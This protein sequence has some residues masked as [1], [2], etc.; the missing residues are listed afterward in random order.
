MIQKYLIED[1][2]ERFNDSIK[3][4]EDSDKSPYYYEKLKKDCIYII[5]KHFERS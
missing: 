2:E 3:R 4:C 5:N 1:I